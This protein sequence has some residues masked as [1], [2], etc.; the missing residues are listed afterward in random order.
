MEE[1]AVRIN[2]NFCFQDFLSQ[3]LNLQI[4]MRDAKQAEVLLS[5]QEHI[6]SK[7][8]TPSNLEQAEGL[9]KRHEALLT[10][11]DANDEKING[12]IQFASNMCREGHS[13][14]DK[15]GKKADSIRER[16][17]NNKQKALEQLEKL[18]EQLQLHQF[19]QDCEELGEWVQEKSM[20]A[21]DET[22]RSAKTV[23]SKWTRHQAFE[24]E[25]ASNKDRLTAIQEAAQLLIQ[26]KPEFAQYLKP[27][28]SELESHF[29]DLE[30]ST[31]EKAINLLLSGF[32]TNLYF[33]T[34]IG[35]LQGE[36]LFDANRQVL[37]EQTCDDIDT[38]ITDLEKQIDQGDT[39]ADLASVNILMQKQQV[40]F[41]VQYKYYGFMYKIQLQ[42]TPML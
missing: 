2:N 33:N 40:R 6:L 13:Q 3:N 15:I 28:V 22:Y 35:Y 24:A 34:R 18:K 42:M 41:S 1:Y 4:F 36:R 31:K 37:Y 25:I 19:L 32:M 7:D 23:H 8:E 27:K 21:Q 5:Q 20:I 10:T 30:R 26:E 16:R 39:G 14:A 9:I 17:D 11:M 38:W 12:V 29:D